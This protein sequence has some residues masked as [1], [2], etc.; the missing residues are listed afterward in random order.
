MEKLIEEIGADAIVNYIKNKTAD[1]E[2]KDFILSEIQSC[3][4]KFF[5]GEYYLIN[6]VYTLFKCSFEFNY[7]YYDYFKIYLILKEKY[8]INNTKTNEI[9]KEILVENLKYSELPATT[10]PLSLLY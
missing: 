5:N 3:K 8:K 9:I 4:I 1:K 7:F 10:M 6:D 2:M